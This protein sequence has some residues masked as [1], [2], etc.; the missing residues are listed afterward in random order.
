[1]KKDKL[2]IRMILALLIL[3]S[4]LITV[5]VFDIKTKEE[6]VADLYNG[7]ATISENGKDISS[8]IKEKYQE[9]Y[10]DGNYRYIYKNIKDYSYRKHYD[11]YTDYAV[12]I[13]RSEK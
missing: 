6:Y 8:S 1:M 11:D 10:E 7:Y 3:C 13:D 2:I 9:E 5:L 4:G 12:K